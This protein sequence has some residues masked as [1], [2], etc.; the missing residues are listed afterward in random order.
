MADTEAAQMQIVLH[1]LREIDPRGGG[2]TAS[3]ICDL[4]AEAGITDRPVAF[5]SLRDSLGLLLPRV[6]PHALGLLFKRF[7]KRWLGDLRLIGLPTRTRAM[8]W[9]VECRAQPRAGVER[10]EVA[11]PTVGEVSITFSGSG[12][13]LAALAA[14]AE[15]S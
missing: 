8:R 2:L 14:S 1:A 3:E 15:S 13:H 7:S 5:H 11:A 4:C 12:T 9:W 10:E 6:T